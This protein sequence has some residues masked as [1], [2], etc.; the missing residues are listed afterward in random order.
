MTTSPC[1][2]IAPNCL[3]NAIFGMFGLAATLFR[4]Y[5]VTVLL[6]LNLLLGKNV[7]WWFVHKRIFSI[8]VK[9]FFQQTDDL[10]QVLRERLSTII[11]SPPIY[12]TF[13]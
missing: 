1:L 5:A 13:Q 6:I 8:H 3:F 4:S 11:R 7:Y 12:V 2:G 9:I 10:I